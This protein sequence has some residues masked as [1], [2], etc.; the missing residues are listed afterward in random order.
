MAAPAEAEGGLKVCIQV[1]GDGSISVGVEDESAEPA[2]QEPTPGAAPVPGQ[3]GEDEAAEM[4]NMQPAGSI[5]EALKIARQLLMQAP[6]PAGP[7]EQSAA[8][9]AFTAA[10]GR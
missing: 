2:E 8:S 4:G 7:T 3:G 10:R 1:A 9:D 6:Q 5:D